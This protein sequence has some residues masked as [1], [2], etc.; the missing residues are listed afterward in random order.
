MN[1]SCCNEYEPD[2][3]SAPGETL[4]EI[5]DAIEMSQADLARQTG[6]T[7][8]TI[9]EIIKGEAPI[10]PD[11][12]RQLERVLG[13]PARLWNSLERNYRARRASMEE[14]D[15]LEKQAAK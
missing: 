15:R 10:T 9:N 1:S 8:E 11:T 7:A 14:Q 13:V 2:Y 12:A 4:Q 3:P 6:T 5:L